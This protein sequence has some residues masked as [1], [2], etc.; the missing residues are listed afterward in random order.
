MLSSLTPET[1]QKSLLGTRKGLGTSAIR[2]GVSN[3]VEEAMS[4]DEIETDI[5]EQERLTFT[6]LPTGLGVSAVKIDK[7]AG[8]GKKA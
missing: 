7:W 3:Q 5:P 1:I 2:L 8:L 4:T 6:G